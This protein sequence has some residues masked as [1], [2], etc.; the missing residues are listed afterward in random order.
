MLKKIL[1][2]VAAMSVFFNMTFALTDNLQIL[3]GALVF[4]EDAVQTPLPETSPVPEDSPVPSESEEPIESASPEPSPTRT[5]RPV[6]TP[7]PTE[8]PGASPTPAPN[9][10]LS[11]GDIIIY[12][13][14]TYTFE[15]LET[16]YRI[17]VKDNVD[18]AVIVLNN[19]QMKSKGPITIGENCGVSVLYSGTNS[20]ESTSDNAAVIIPESSVLNLEGDGTLSAVSSGAA[21]G[22]DKTSAGVINIKSGTLNAESTGGGAAIGGGA[23][24]NSSEINI[25]GAAVHAKAKNGAAIGGGS[26]GESENITISGG[27]IYAE[28]DGGAAI[29]GGAGSE[30]K[31]IT[32]SGGNIE[33]HCGAGNAAIGGG[34]RKSGGR[35]AISGGNI[36]GYAGEYGRIVGGGRYSVTSRVSVTGNAEIEGFVKEGA[37]AAE[38]NEISGT[39]PMICA[40][41]SYDKSSSYNRDDIPD[42]EQVINM[43][44]GTYSDTVTLPKGY[45]GFIKTLGTTGTYKLTTNSGTPIQNI[46]YKT[47]SGSSATTISSSRKSSNFDISSGINHFILSP[48]DS[49]YLDEIEFKTADIVLTEKQIKKTVTLSSS[50]RKIVP[51]TC[52]SSAHKSKSIKYSYEIVSDESNIAELDEKKLTVEVSDSGTYPITLKITAECGDL[53]IEKTQ[54]LNVIKQSASHD[55]SREDLN[56]TNNG[57]YTVK[58]STTRYNINVAPNLNDVGIILSSSLSIDMSKN[59]TARKSPVVIGDNSNVTF[60]CTSS[61]NL[62]STDNGSCI[63]AGKNSAV[64]IN[65]N[66]GSIRMESFDSGNCIT[67]DTVYLL[68]GSFSL[69]AKKGIPVKANKLFIADAVDRFSGWSED[70][71]NYPITAEYISE[72]YKS[73]EPAYIIQGKLSKSFSEEDAS[74][75]LQRVSY[76]SSSSKNNSS[77]R[78]SSGSS[79]TISSLSKDCKSFVLKVSSYGNY[80]ASFRDDGNVSKDYTIKDGSRNISEI[81]LEEEKTYISSNVFSYNECKCKLSA[82]VFTMENIVMPYEKKSASYALD[83]EDAEL[84]VDDDCR[85]HSSGSHADYN[86]TIDDDKEDIATIRGDRIYFDVPKPGKYTVKVTATASVDAIESSKSVSVSVT[87]LSEEETVK[88]RGELHSAYIKGYDDDTFRPDN[89]ITRAEAATILASALNI[90]SDR[91]AEIGFYDVSRKAWYY[92]N[93][94]AAEQADFFSGYE[95]GSFKPDNNITRAEFTVAVCNA[96]GVEI[97]SKSKSKSKMEDINE[98]WAKDYVDALVKTKYI[99]GYED[100]SFKPDNNITRAEAV[101][102]LNRALGR[103]VDEKKMTGVSVNNPFDDIKKNHWAFYDIMEA[104]NDHYAKEW[105]KK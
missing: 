35:I 23:G 46:V 95:D 86:Y 91:D 28:S 49:C 32:I 5:P 58:G 17:I 104:V 16:A 43:S 25:T 66:S 39:I 74:I 100:G 98:H 70:S 103:T 90:E 77:S 67:A 26:G 12:E 11:K 10:D 55:I 94:L 48:S 44:C 9:A 56:I 69:T 40:F 15:N 54:I 92:D 60:T 6:R 62:K 78:N 84:T 82:P 42:S 47:S 68:D 14:G 73:Y 45:H 79:A 3:S 81:T 89:N 30:S 4:A 51:T 105:H 38:E 75:T 101:A 76:K 61:A 8:E 37:C 72:P 1:S 52:N 27:D 24:Q 64:T 97:R 36:V 29:G 21:V 22:S 85:D 18:N 65:G 59:T 63:D 53:T 19:V 33:V 71:K 31:N 20:L 2:A 50:T 93:I 34:Y 80:K 87:R 57:V 99:T 83:A 41:Y 88:Q 7:R 102:I 13:N 96:F